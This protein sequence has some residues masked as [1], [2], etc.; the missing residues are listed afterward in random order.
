[1]QLLTIEFLR[2]ILTEVDFIATRVG[3]TTF[4]AFLLDEV[5]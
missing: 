1:M 3:D 2:D 5:K 4:D